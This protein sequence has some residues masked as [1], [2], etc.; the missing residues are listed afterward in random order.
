[1]CGIAG[2]LGRQGDLSSQR[3]WEFGSLMVESLAHRGPD[4]SGIWLDEGAGLVLGHRRLSVL[5]LS[6]AGK[7]PMLSA[8]GRFVISFN[9]EVYN[10]GSLRKRISDECSEMRFRGQSDT[11]VVLAA[12]ELWGFPKAVGEF[13][14]MFAIAAWDRQERLLYLSRDRFGEKPL[15]YAKQDAGVFFGSELKAFRAN[16]RFRAAVNREAITL[17]LRYGYMPA[18]VSIYE[19]VEKVAAGCYLVVDGRSG[20]CTPVTYWS[21]SATAETC[22]VQMFRGTDEEAVREAATLLLDAVRMRMVSDVPLGAFLSGGVDSSAVVAL[23]QAASSRPVKT[24]TIGFEDPTYNEAEHAKAVSRHLGTDHTELYVTSQQAMEVIPRLPELYDE[25]FADSSQ[26]PTFL[27]S[28]MAR[29]KVTVSLSGD[30]GDEVFGGYTRYFWT[31]RIWKKLRYAP[32]SARTALGRVLGALPPGAWTAAFSV[33]NPLLPRDLRIRNPI[34]KMQKLYKMLEARS[35]DDVYLHL[36]SH[37]DEPAKIVLN[38]TE[39]VA[40]L[41]SM[42]G[43]RAPA[44]LTRRM[45]LFDALTYLPD[46]IMVKVDRASMAVSLESR[47]PFLDH[48]IF[49]FAASLPMDM[50]IRKGQGKWILRRVLEKYVPLVLFDRPKTGFGIPV[51]AWLRGPLRDW[52]EDLLSESRLRQEGYFDPAPIVTKWREHVRGRQNWFYPLWNV[53]M[54]QAWLANQRSSLK[55]SLEPST[56]YQQ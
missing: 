30:G 26:I 2:F 40:G 17:L 15:Y 43:L 1:M 36:M 47:A 3:L 32:E 4:D 14:G 28:Q 23:M 49:E 29:S 52:A 46:D 9:G 34:D 22:S 48:R 37:W 33:L 42:N 53:L 21:A 44:D 25:P 20:R 18:P 13:N 50:L 55:P 31:Q 45:M 27:V 24:F 5:E 54:F 38:S 10:Y 16:P 6:S 56:H 11:E 12:I 8:S 51:H 39:P 35:A 7:Q 19:G 41:R